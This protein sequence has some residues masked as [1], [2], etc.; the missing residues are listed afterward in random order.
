MSTTRKSPRLDDP[1]FDLFRGVPTEGGSTEVRAARHSGRRFVSGNSSGMFV[2]TI[3]LEHYLRDMGELTPLSVAR[4][5]DEQDWQVFEQRY[6]AT[7]RAPYAPRA[8][9]GLILYGIMQGV[10]SLR[11]LER[12]ARLDLG[13]MWVSGGI[14]PDHAI[15]GRFIVLHEASLTHEFF[16]SLTRSILHVCRS[17]SQRVAGDGTVIEAACSHYRLLK[18]QAVKAQ[19]EVARKRLAQQPADSHAQQA[20][21]HAQECEQTFEQRKA[22]RRKRG[23]GT[24]SLCISASEPQAMV[25]RLKRGRGFAASYTPSVLANEDRIITAMAVDGSSETSVMAQMLDQHARIA[26]SQTK[27]VLLDAGYFDDEVIAAT[28]ERDVSLLCPSGQ[29]PAPEEKSTGK[30]HKSR[31][32]YDPYTDTY[33]CPADQILTRV[34][35]VAPSAVTREQTV[36]APL[37]CSG[38][39]LRN[40]CTS[41]KVRKIKRYPEDEAREAL[42]LVMEQPEA[43]RAFCQRK[44]MVEPVFAMLRYQQK[45]DRFRRRGLAAVKREFALHAMAYNLARA[46]VLLKALFVYFYAICLVQ[47]AHVARLSSPRPHTRGYHQAQTPSGNLIKSRIT[48]ENVLRQ[49]L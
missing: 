25:Q 37:S 28:L 32:Q 24:D 43:Q 15:I 4:L 17:S 16:E 39:P 36:Y 48:Q 21:R 5:L 10:H 30:F 47:S 6:A 49:S 42:R 40:R 29:W 7:G 13:C 9:M 35:K 1:Q 31:F 41:A 45:L 34:S 33:R 38:C 23:K 44:A 46:A 27:E 19:T 26:G 20:M 22:S 8:M 2:G 18:E 12:L 3:R 11:A 14:T